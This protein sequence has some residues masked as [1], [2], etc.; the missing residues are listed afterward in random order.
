LPFPGFG[1]WIVTLDPPAVASNRAAFSLNDP[2]N[3]GIS[4]GSTSGD[5]GGIDWGQAQI[6]EYLAQQGEYGSTV[7]DYVIPN[8]TVT[9]PIGIGMTE[10]GNA[11]DPELALRNLS[12]KVGLL[13]REGGW[14]MRQRLLSNGSLGPPTYAD[15][16][17][18]TL[19][20]AD[21]W[22]ETAGVEPGFTLTLT[23][24][25]DFYGDE[26]T[27][28]TLY[29]TGFCSKVLTSGG[30]PAVIAGDYPARS[31]LQVTDASG[32]NQS[33]LLWGLQSRY[34]DPASTAVLQLQ[35]EQQTLLNGTVAATLAGA[36][37]G[38]VAKLVTTSPGEMIASVAFSGTHIGTYRLLIRAYSST[39]DAVFQLEWATSDGSLPTT[40]T[41][42]ALP[43]TGN[44]YV[45][46]LGIIRVDASP[47]GLSAWFGIISAEVA[48]TEHDA[49]IDEIFLVPLN[50]SAGSLDAATV[51]N[52]ATVS[53]QDE[54]PG[55][56]VSS[57]SGTAW[58]EPSAGQWD[59]T[60]P[61]GGSSQTLKLTG[62]GFTIP[63]GY[64]I[65]SATLLLIAVPSAG[66]SIKDTLVQ[67]T[68]AGV[69]IGN[70]VAGLGTGEDS[71]GYWSPARP[72]TY[73][74]WGVTLTSAIINSSTFGVEIAVEN[75]SGSSVSLRMEPGIIIEYAPT[76]G[77]I[78]SDATVFANETLELRYDGMYR[79]ADGTYYAPAA[80]VI[81]DLARIPP[82]GMEDRP[83][84]V[85][86]K[87]LRDN[88]VGTAQ[89]PALDA[90][91]VTPLV[92][93]AYLSRI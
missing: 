9:I 70:N 58:T 38:S 86:V 47:V 40:N 88:W 3:S 65:I 22:M 93:P 2:Q 19:T 66:G 4:I 90:F 62:C 45:L 5:S 85:F 41:A 67:L 46:D 42:V 79:T 63:T 71:G 27:F 30:L 55:T 48:T 36:S 12:M 26:V 13:Q 39:E 25:P 11:P 23:C 73:N 83:A 56:W 35:A 16:V 31:R 77:I 6:T 74:G 34:Y 51:S 49:Q 18:A 50:E 87:P 43:G 20:P 92:R 89:D 17:D 69:P 82:S 29:C 68:N 81:G 7:A 54:V 1:G 33:G 64:T 75:T 57:G 59:L 60:L 32:N 21:D 8:R 72:I 24:I 10:G 91:T 14:L 15:I 52:P 80:N 28:D 84:R 76:G 61:A 44:F 53:S 37:N 78:S